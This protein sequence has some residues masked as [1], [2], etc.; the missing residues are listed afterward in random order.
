MPN[1]K[2]QKQSAKTK[3]KQTQQNRVHSF[4]PSCCIIYVLQPESSLLFLTAAAASLVGADI[5]AVHSSFYQRCNYSILYTLVSKV[6]TWE[7]WACWSLFMYYWSR[8]FL[9]KQAQFNKTNYLS[10][11]RKDK[12]VISGETKLH[13]HLSNKTQQDVSLLWETPWGVLMGL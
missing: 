13:Q 4:L 10:M 11:P 9:E 6:A 7:K 2:L 12:W 5:R 3:E 1:K 8:L